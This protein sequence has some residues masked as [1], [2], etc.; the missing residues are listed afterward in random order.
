MLGRIFRLVGGMAVLITVA[1]GLG[2]AKSFGQFFALFGGM[3]LGW[4]FQAPVSGFAAWILVS[5]K[6]PFR[7]G[8][9]VQ[10]P[11]LRLTGDVHDIGPMYAMLDQVGGTIGSEEAVGRYILMPVGPRRTRRRPARAIRTPGGI[12][13]WIW[14]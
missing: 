14:P 2:Q 10:F 11:N 7:P 12:G 3:I 13:T 5:V 9:R 8:D 1:Y 6:R 4:S